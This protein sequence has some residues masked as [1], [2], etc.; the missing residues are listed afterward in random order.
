[1]LSSSHPY[2]LKIIVTFTNQNGRS[3]ETADK[4]NLTLLNNK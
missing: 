4:V 3:L 1:M 2:L